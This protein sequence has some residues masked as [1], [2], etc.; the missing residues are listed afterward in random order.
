M[1]PIT[2]VIAALS[3]I[4]GTDASTINL[5][6]ILGQNK[7]EI[8]SKVQDLQGSRLSMIKE[9]VDILANYGLGMESKH[10]VICDSS[11]TLGVAYSTDPQNTRTVYIGQS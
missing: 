7:S 5:D 9:T 8:F 2:I 1:T 3:V 10:V 11:D 6:Q 4:S